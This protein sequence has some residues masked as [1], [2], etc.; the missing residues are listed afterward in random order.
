MKERPFS[1]SRVPLSIK[2]TQ[3]INNDLQI[4][5]HCEKTYQGKERSH[6]YST[7]NCLASDYLRLHRLEGRFSPL[8]RSSLSEGKTLQ[9]SPQFN[10]RPLCFL[11][12][13]F[14]WE[15]TVE[16]SHEID[17]SLPPLTKV[18]F[19]L[20]TFSNTTWTPAVKWNVTPMHCS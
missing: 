1:I 7:A 5:D 13:K 8:K 2:T 4:D 19:S 9:W 17:S 18:Y 6:K 15:L 20:L 11:L 3:L 16:S 10:A 14:F 12:I